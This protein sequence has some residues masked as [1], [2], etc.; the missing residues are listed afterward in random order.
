MT[1]ID[2]L[3]ATAYET[4]IDPIDYAAEHVIRAHVA[5]WLDWPQGT[6]TALS[7]RIVADL[8]NAGWTAPA[9]AEG[10]EP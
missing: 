10:A 9:V 2:I 8:L 3:A 1:D 4:G 7:R 6:V 5:A